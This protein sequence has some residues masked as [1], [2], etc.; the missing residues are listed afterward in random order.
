MTFTLDALKRWLGTGLVLTLVATA[1]AALASDTKG[2]IQGAPG[3]ERPDVTLHGEAYSSMWDLSTSGLV[4][5]DGRSALMKDRFHSGSRIVVDSHGMARAEIKD[6]G[7]ISISPRSEVILD[8]VDDTIV[9][10]MLQGSMKIEASAAVST[11]VETPDTKIVSYPGTFV[12]YRVKA[13]PLA[14]TSLVK[15]L[16][17]VAILA[18]ADD[19]RAGLDID[20]P[21]GDN[22]FHMK[23]RNSETLKVKVKNSGSPV[24]NQPVIFA[25]TTALDG[26][27]GQ[28]TEGV[29]RITTTTDND[30]I[31][32]VDFESGASSGAV[33][34]EAFIP[35]TDAH[36]TLH[37]Y[38][39]AKEK[40]FWNP[41]TITL[42][43]AL[44]AGCV[45]GGVLAVVNS[46]DDHTPTNIVVQ[47]PVVTGP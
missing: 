23:A 45:A 21:D 6:V 41:G 33:Y 32:S 25:I 9:A 1:P 29:Q 44:A 3:T 40:T 37:V 13:D 22:D 35:G 26:A 43:T 2:T 4:L 12:T 30:G 38:I 10:R 18:S 15:S 34:V 31:A 27:T 39:R 11:Y 47:P 17:D 16:G 14:G 19:S 8:M 7:R 20:V 24:A 46:G 28:F 36:E 5:V 42:Y